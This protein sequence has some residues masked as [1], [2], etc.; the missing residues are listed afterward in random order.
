[1]AKHWQLTNPNKVP[2]SRQ[3]NQPS[4]KDG[5]AA[6]AVAAVTKFTSAI[7]SYTSPISEITASTKHT[8]PAKDGNDNDDA[9][10]PA[11][12]WERNG[13]N[14]AVAGRQERLPKKAK[15]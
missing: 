9:P 13:N 8:T 7:S 2:G 14:S 12:G 6:G 15:N 10:K 11:W 1:M 4:K 3:T 5:A